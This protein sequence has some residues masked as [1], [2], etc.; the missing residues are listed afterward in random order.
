[1]ISADIKERVKKLREQI[2]KFR[3]EYHV[4]DNLSISPE[5]LDSLKRELF[6]LEEKYPELITKDSP[7]QRV[8]GV[9]LDEFKK[10][11]HKVSQWS[12]NDAFTEEDLVAFDERIKKFLSKEGINHNPS[13]DCELKID[14]LKIVITY[15]KGLLV[16]AATRGDGKV[17]EDVTHN[18]KTIESVPLKLSEPLNIIVEGEV[19]MSKK[20]FEQLNNERHKKGDSL[21]ANPRNIAA[22]SIRQLDPKIAEERRLSAFI[23]DIASVVGADFP[24]TQTE[25]LK[26]LSK[27]GFKVNT[28]HRHVKDIDGV[29][30]FW[31]EWK[32]KAPQEDYWIDGVVIK[33]DE[34]EYQDVLGYTGKAP[35]WGIAFK[36][37]AEEVTTVVEDVFFQIGRTGVITP[38]AK[39]TPVLV[40]GSTV[41]RATLHNEDEIKRLGLKI[42]DTIILKKAGDV[43]PDIVS[44][45]ESLR[46]GKEKTIK[47]PK[48]CP[49]CE[50]DLVRK[51]IASGSK[52]NGKEE[53]STAYYCTNRNCSGKDRRKLYYFT[54]KHAFDIEGLG[55]KI[56]DLLLDNA[57]IQNSSDIFEI[58]KEDLLALPRFAEKSADNLIESINNKRKISL[59]RFII[60]LSISQVGE[61]TAEDLAERFGNI[62]KFLEA[63]KEELELIEGIGPTVAHEIDI[64]KKDPVNIH[65]IQKLLKHVRVENTAKK[66]GGKFIGKSFVL[67]GT[68]SSMGRDEAKAKIKALGGNISSA[69]SKNTSFVV[70]GADSGSKFDKA[71]ELGVHILDEKSFLEMLKN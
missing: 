14:G 39:L 9:A 2:E 3:Y 45:I 55:P 29:I 48:Q 64:W 44:V 63:S 4:L 43:I 31:K 13:Y 10:V 57:V 40:A 53:L 8:A 11:P 37:P 38:V 30:K 71:K 34:K 52:K 59:S 26:L 35:R 46:T 66:I 56:I 61:E 65:L 42:G 18:V 25:E 24:K 51:E 50:H 36:F 12:F 33:V 20:V 67:T 15:E 68:L 62:N 69:V 23:Y 47:M 28:H 6:S 5:A 7:T 27:L 49:A 60:A 32:D 22:G 70:A 21:F 16:Q 54:S 41:S 19:W 17:G 58:K 1:M